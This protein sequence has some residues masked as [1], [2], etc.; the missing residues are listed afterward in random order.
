MSDKIG[1][2]I[3]W[4]GFWLGLGLYL[5][6]HVIAVSAVDVTKLVMGVE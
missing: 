1:D 3:G 4:A 5:G 2:G 6:L